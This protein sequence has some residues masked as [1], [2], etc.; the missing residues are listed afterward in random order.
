MDE[1]WQ[2]FKYS[3][4][5]ALSNFGSAPWLYD[6]R[7]IFPRAT[8]VTILELVNNKSQKIAEV[9][10]EYSLLDF[11]DKKIDYTE[12]LFLGEYLND[13]SE[14]L[15]TE[16]YLEVIENRIQNRDDQNFELS[17]YQRIL[18]LISKSWIKVVQHQL[19]F[20]SWID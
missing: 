14:E 7:I 15:Y 12:L 18:N 16:E 6:D 2:V 1:R 9:I 17:E 8:W 4:K 20:N 11:N 3:D 13:L 19:I 10:E 5:Q